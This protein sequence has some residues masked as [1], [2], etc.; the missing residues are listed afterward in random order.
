[1]NSAIHFSFSLIYTANINTANVKKI[2]FKN[3]Q[4]LE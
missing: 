3:N 4:L 1:M 2:F